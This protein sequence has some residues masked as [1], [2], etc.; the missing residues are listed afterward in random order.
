LETP[1]EKISSVEGTET[2]GYFLLT[3]FAAAFFRF[4]ATL[5]LTILP[6][7]FNGSGLSIGNCTAPFELAY[8]DNSLSNA[9]IPLGAG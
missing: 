3:G 9:A 2:T 5:N 6:I 8:F 4:S 7:N 1:G